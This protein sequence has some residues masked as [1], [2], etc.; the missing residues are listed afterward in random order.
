MTLNLDALNTAITS[1]NDALW[2]YLLI[3]A[4]IICGLYFT[5]RT[6]FVQFAMLGNMF[7]QL[8]DTSPACGGRKHISSF[9]AFAVSVAT[10]VCR[11][12]PGSGVLDVG[13]RSNRLSDSLCR[14]NISTTL[15]ASRQ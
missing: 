12:W 7:R 6:R 8:F 14:G 15:Q 5:V 9:Q 4:L 2:T 3:G 1:V 11:R 10:R 13:N